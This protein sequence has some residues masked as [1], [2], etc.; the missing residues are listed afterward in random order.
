MTERIIMKTILHKAHTRG[1]FNHG[2]LDTHHTFSFAD[3]FDPDRVHFG[4][5]R[6]LNDDTVA[7]QEG[8]G[9]HSHHNMEIVSIPL[10]GDLEHRDSMG[11]RAVINKGQIQ[12]MSAGTGVRHS[13]YNKNDDQNVAFLQIWVLPDRENVEP[14]YGEAVIAD[15]V[16]R[17]KLSEIVT[18]YPGN[19]KG[20]WIYQQAWFSLGELDKGAVVTYDLKSKISYGV[21][22]FVIQGDARIND[23]IELNK[24]DGLG[25]SETEAFS[26]EALTDAEV[27]LIEVPPLL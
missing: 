7:P 25:I 23:E 2:W 3:Y 24:R 26:I 11:N 21:Y 27:L 19:G 18:P 4:M 13:E 8:F 9:M 12:V 14:R 5:L 10:S 1:H 16:E 17:N 6:V 20:L 15:L 22:V